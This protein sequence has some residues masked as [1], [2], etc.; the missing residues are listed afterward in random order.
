MNRFHRSSDFGTTAIVLI[1]FG[2]GLLVKVLK[3]AAFLSIKVLSRGGFVP[4]SS[5]IPPELV[6]KL[7][8]LRDVRYMKESTAQNTVGPNRSEWRRPAAKI[9]RLRYC[10]R[11]RTNVP[12]LPP[13]IHAHPAR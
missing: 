1:I 3:T 7:A 2:G 10:T 13:Q 12:M 11:Y 8:D 6:E 9:L 5:T 4:R